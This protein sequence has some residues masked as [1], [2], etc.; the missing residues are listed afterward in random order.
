MNL[1]VEEFC[2][3]CSACFAICPTRAITMCFDDEGFLQPNIDQVKCINCD[4]CKSVCP[5]SKN[6]LKD[7]YP[8]CYALKTRARDILMASTSG[9]AFSEIAKPILESNGCVF[10]CVIQA[11]DLC[12]CHTKVESWDE[13]SKIRGSKYV[14]SDL[15]NTFKECKVE[16]DK[17]REVLYSGTSCQIAGLKAFLCRDYENLTTVDLICHGVP[18]PGVFEKYKQDVEAAENA[19]IKSIVFRHKDVEKRFSLSLT[20]FNDRE[21]RSYIKYD[22][23]FFNAF[24][25]DL[26]LRSSC[27]NCRFREGRSGSDYTI[28]DFW[29]IEKCNVGLEYGVEGVSLVIAH[30][31]KAKAFMNGCIEVPFKD[32]LRGNPSYFLAPKLTERRN[33]FFRLIKKHSVKFATERL[34]EGPSYLR[35]AK[36]VFRSVKHFVKGVLKV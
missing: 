21:K 4:L 10:G 22:R 9:G 23:T 5:V 14:Q 31:D 24:I 35:F 25:N 26:C 16:L 15:K 28:A 7:D 20:M 19:K 8:K 17:G 29:Q 34:L 18:S 30:T 3:G 6:Y 33:K 11:S 13:L 12:V 32:A 36:R 27:Y 1:A 2:S